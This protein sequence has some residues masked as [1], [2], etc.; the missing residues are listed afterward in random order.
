MVFYES[1]K[2]RGEKNKKPRFGRGF[3]NGQLQLISL[4]T[5]TKLYHRFASDESSR[6]PP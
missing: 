1:Q 5:A 6:S 4:Q 2:I 3:L